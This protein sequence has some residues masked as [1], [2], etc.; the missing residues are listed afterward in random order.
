MDDEWDPDAGATKPFDAVARHGGDDARELA[1]R[2]AD[3]RRL[4]RALAE[5]EA[6]RA[7]LEAELAAFQRRYFAAFGR[8]YAELDELDARI[9]EQAAA[10][11]PDDASKQ[12]RAERARARVEGRGARP[13]PRE[14]AA[15]PAPSDEL[16]TL[17]RALSK[18]IHPDHA[19]DE[20]ER[21]AREVLMVKANLAYA[22]GDVEALQAMHARGE[23]PAEAVPDALAQVARRIAIAEA[24]LARADAERAHREASDLARLARRVAKAAEE[25]RDLFPKFRAEL[26]DARR[27]A[28]K[29]L[30]ALERRAAK[31]G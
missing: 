27:Q 31:R 2:E 8:L 11:R 24:Q 21:R 28:E 22:A 13:A 17:Y 12:R 19:A 9:A 7:A 25:G 18:R 10:V 4:E 14:E 3:L 16:R 1:R 23:A 5:R 15:R 20:G 26:E 29:R 30:R 6:A